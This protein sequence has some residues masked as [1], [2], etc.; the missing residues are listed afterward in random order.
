MCA[1]VTSAAFVQIASCFPLNGDFCYTAV[2]NLN[3]TSELRVADFE[4][5]PRFGQHTSAGRSFFW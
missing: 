1:N 5:A 2:A 3:L 4:L